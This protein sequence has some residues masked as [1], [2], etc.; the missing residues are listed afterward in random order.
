MIVYL[1][2]LRQFG[3]HLCESRFDCLA[4][5]T[6]TNRVCFGKKLRFVRVPRWSE[7]RFH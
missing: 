4:T 5:L 1:A 6:F 2:E 7:T 3:A